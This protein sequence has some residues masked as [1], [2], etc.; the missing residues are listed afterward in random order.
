MIDLDDLE[1]VKSL[2]LSWHTWWAKDISSYYCRATEYIGVFNGKVKAKT[3]Y[4]HRVI[5]GDEKGKYIDHLNHDTLD[6]RKSNLF[7]TSSRINVLNRKSANKNNS[8]G[9]RNVSYDK[10]HDKYIVQMQIDGKN[11]RIGVF[12]NLID[13]TKCA[14]KARKEIYDL[15]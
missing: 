13:A 9:V 6:N 5:M 2:N 8:T 11:T 7:S 14:E 12:D 1:K 15:H 3:H 4:L 10:T